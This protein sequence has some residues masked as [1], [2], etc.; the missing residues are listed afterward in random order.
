MTGNAMA[1]LV[2]AGAL[3]A[4]LAA[5]TSD[6]PP[7]AGST[8][9]ASTPAPDASPDAAAIQPLD[10]KVKGVQ[11]MWTMTSA[12]LTTG[13]GMQITGENATDT[14]YFV[15]KGTQPGTFECLIGGQLS[16]VAGVLYKGVEG[17][18]FSAGVTSNGATCTITATTVGPVGGKVS[19]YFTSMPAN[20]SASLLI[21]G[22]FN[23]DRVADE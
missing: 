19:G 18:N 16:G 10:V 21:E 12:Q 17:S 6:S 4:S 23:V 8:P 20:G 1:T 13:G 7:P 22:K 15:F 14:L 3:I 11:K 9:D 2:A 5:C